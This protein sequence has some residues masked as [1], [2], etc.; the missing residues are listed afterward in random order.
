MGG[1]DPVS[2][3]ITL[4]LLPASM[5]VRERT[6]HWGRRKELADITLLI[7][8]IAAQQGI[9][10]AEGRR[11][12]SVTIHKSM[13]SRVRDDPANRDSR[14]KSVLD[15]MVATGLLKDDNDRWLE[16]NGVREGDKRESFETVIEFWDCGE[17][18]KSAA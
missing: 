1:C 18:N 10:V 6:S 15:A 4:P 16:W 7:K 12:V 17:F 5:N 14:A 8:T 2:W 11:A 9:P 3:T 13:R